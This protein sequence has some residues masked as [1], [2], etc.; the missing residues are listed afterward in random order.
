MTSPT[1]VRLIICALIASALLFLNP[2]QTRDPLLNKD[3]NYSLTPVTR[4]RGNI[5]RSTRA[6]IERAYGKLPMR[7]EANEGQTDARVK[8]KSRGAGYAVFL[9]GDE[10]VLQLR[11]PKPGDESAGELEKRKTS[12]MTAS[13]I[14]FPV[15]LSQLPA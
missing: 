1:L 7:F 12:I 10:A 6:R 4:D 8:F 5:D 9:T 3:A 2:D 14:L 11:K 15:F 13:L